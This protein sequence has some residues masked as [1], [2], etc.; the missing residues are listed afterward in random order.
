MA[1]IH[2]LRQTKSVFRLRG[3][4]GGLGADKFIEENA[5]STGKKRLNS[6]FFVKTT[7]EN[8]IYLNLNGFEKSNVYYSYRDGD[9][10]KSVAIPWVDRFNENLIKTQVG[11]HEATLSFSKRAKIEKSGDGKYITKDLTDYDMIEYLKK[12]RDN[13]TISDGQGVYVS[14]RV[15]PPSTY[16]D[17]DGNA[18]TMSASLDVNAIYSVENFDFDKMTEEQLATTSEFEMEII[19]KECRK[20]EGKTTMVAYVVGSDYVEEMEFGFEDEGIAET[21]DKFLTPYSKI[22][23]KGDITYERQEKETEVK[24][25]GIDLDRWQSTKAKKTGRTIPNQSTTGSSRRVFVIV[26]ADPNSIDTE[27]YTKE[28][29]EEAISAIKA[30]KE[31]NGRT[32]KPKEQNTLNFGKDKYSNSGFDTSG[33]DDVKDFGSDLDLDDDDF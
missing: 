4:L 10:Y 22:C 12:L 26:N 33:F 31:F 32:S 2:E 24:T 7:P 17:K 15:V 13:G 28:G 3:L 8:N 21:F 14:G 20:I 25:T 6:R 11:D 1:K 27:A 18:H 29:I 19:K 9:S 30:H 23:V 5:T 16:Y